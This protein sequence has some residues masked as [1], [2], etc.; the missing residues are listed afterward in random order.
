MSDHV[1]SMAA[2][3]AAALMLVSFDGVA[4]AQAPAATPT[5]AP[6]QTPA[7]APTPPPA[8]TPA[9]TASPAPGANNANTL[10]SVTVTAPHFTQVRKRPKT[11]V[12]STERSN[13]PVTTPQAPEQIQAEANKQIVQRT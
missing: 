13:V 7:P 3:G 9:P 4:L 11:H 6:A 5:P 12:V 8:Q 10:P 2:C 1:R